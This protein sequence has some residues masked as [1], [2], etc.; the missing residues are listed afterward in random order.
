[1]CCCNQ[2]HPW[3]AK[4]IFFH[5]NDSDRNSNNERGHLNLLMWQYS[6]STAKPPK[7]NS[8]V[9]LI[10]VNN[11]ALSLNFY[12]NTLHHTLQWANYA[13]IEFFIV[14]C[15][16]H[17]KWAPALKNAPNHCRKLISIHTLLFSSTGWIITLLRADISC[18]NN[19]LT[20][21]PE[22]LAFIW[23]GISFKDKH[24]TFFSKK[25]K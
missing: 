14:I 22:V 15:S 2:E 11:I 1:M 3:G 18:L 4:I 8:Q 17:T 25:I 16:M 9:L 7:K 5:T 20:L 24:G 23:R 13:L 19:V 10:L 12:N 6:L 21:L